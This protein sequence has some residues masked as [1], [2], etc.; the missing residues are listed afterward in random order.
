VLLAD[1]ISF[2]KAY[3]HRIFIN[4]VE[5]A[6]LVAPGEFEFDAERAKV[7]LEKVLYE[8]PFEKVLRS[9]QKYDILR[10]KL[11]KMTLYKYL[12][13]IISPCVTLSMVCPKTDSHSM[14]IVKI[15]H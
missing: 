5:P 10:D 4:F 7:G 1:I 2:G 15:S 11:Q 9:F 12:L 6:G 14:D 3:V 8:Q 13:P